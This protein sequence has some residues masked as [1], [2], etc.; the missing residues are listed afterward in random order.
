MEVN[1]PLKYTINKFAGWIS[2][3]RNIKVPHDLETTPLQIRTHSVFGSGDKLSVMFYPEEGDELAGHI[4]VGFENTLKFVISKCSTTRID[5]SSL[6]IEVDKIWQISK[7]S[8]PRISLQCNGVIVL[9]LELSDTI[10]DNADWK[11]FYSQEVKQIM[12][13]SEDTASEE[14]RPAPG[15]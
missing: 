4:S 8:G 6:P 12:F 3:T 15:N 11:T 2:V 1:V 10:C 13:K 9:D 5:V 7:F 14:Y